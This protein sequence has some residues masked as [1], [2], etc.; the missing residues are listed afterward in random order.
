VLNGFCPN[1]A[2]AGVSLAVLDVSKVLRHLT[3]DRLE[4]QSAFECCLG[5]ESNTAVDITVVY[6]NMLQLTLAYMG[7]S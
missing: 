6:L 3:I 2:A 5:D 1:E 4:D 7:V